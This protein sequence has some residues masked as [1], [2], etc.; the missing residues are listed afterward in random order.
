[1]L[2]K[3]T[4]YTRSNDKIKTIFQIVLHK[5]LSKLENLVKTVYSKF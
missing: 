5:K 2:D 4:I 3:H 1:M